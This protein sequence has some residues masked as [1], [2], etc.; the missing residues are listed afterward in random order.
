[1]ACSIH[2]LFVPREYSAGAL[3]ASTVAAGTRMFEIYDAAAPHNSMIVGTNDP[4]AGLG[5]YLTSGNRRP[6]SGRYDLGADNVLD[7]RS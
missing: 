3:P 5:G 4:D 6:I 2:Q 7:L 1:M